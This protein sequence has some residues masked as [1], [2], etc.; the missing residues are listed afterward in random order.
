MSSLHFDLTGGR[1]RRARRRPYLARLIEKTG[2]APSR[3][4]ARLFLSVLAGVL[5]IHFW[6]DGAR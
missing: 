5:A 6:R 3:L 4:A 2:V 1:G